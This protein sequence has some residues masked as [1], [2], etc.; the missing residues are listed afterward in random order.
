MVAESLDQI[1]GEL[2][3][4]L[5]G[6]AQ[7]VQMGLPRLQSAQIVDR[8]VTRLALIGFR[9]DGERAG[10]EPAARG[11]ISGCWS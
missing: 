6:I 2:A 10:R 5:P 4:A 9:G 8:I 11:R 3:V 7:Q 1:V